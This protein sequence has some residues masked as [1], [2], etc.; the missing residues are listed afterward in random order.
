[1]TASPVLELTLVVVTDEPGW[2]GRE[3]HRAFAAWGYRTL[4]VSLT[5]CHLSLEGSSAGI[6]LPGLDGA[7]PAGVFVRGVPGGSLE[8]VI[9]RLDILHALQALGVVVYNSPRA[10]ERTVDKS[11]TSFLLKHAGLPSPD[12]WVCES[13]QQARTHLLR[14]IARGGRLVLKPVFGSQGE[15]LRLLQRPQDLPMACEVNGLYYLQQ[16]IPP[17][18]D[19]W[20]DWRVFV[21]H[22]QAV[23]AM[24]RHSRHWITNRAQGAS[25]EQVRLDADMTRLAEAAVRAVDIEYAGVDLLRDADGRFLITEVNSIPAWMGLQRATGIRMAELLAEDFI[26]RLGGGQPASLELMS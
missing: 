8:Q 21:I 7:L 6:W 18:G 13:R 22:G 10:I 20:Q 4:N 1:M 16:Y 26:T 9:Q 24:R 23:T 3:L 14:A 2:H 12:T 25:C 15:G 11:M 5:D 17:Q 19:T